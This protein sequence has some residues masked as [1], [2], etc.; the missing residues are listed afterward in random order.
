VGESKKITVKKGQKVI[1]SRYSGTEVIMGEEIYLIV[2]ND[3]ILA[4][5]AK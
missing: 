5:V 3:D 2:K 4:V 1:Y